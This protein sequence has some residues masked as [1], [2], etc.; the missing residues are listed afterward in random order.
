M[1]YFKSS[2][3]ISSLFSSSLNLLTPFLWYGDHGC[4]ENRVRYSN[5]RTYETV[6]FY[7]FIWNMNHC[8]S[9]FC[10]LW[11]NSGC[12]YHTI[13]SKHLNTMTYTKVKSMMN[14]EEIVM[15]ITHFSSM[16]R[17]VLNDKPIFIW[18]STLWY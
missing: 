8:L 17:D 6:I 11:N 10:H 5:L 1:K 13:P 15:F 3:W 12:S 2:I 18:V 16:E 14:I 4:K 9:M 7:A